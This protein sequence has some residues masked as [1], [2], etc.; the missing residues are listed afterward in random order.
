MLIKG[1]QTEA[2]ILMSFEKAR[3]DP[4]CSEMELRD[5]EFDEILAT[6]FIDILNTK[7][8]SKVRISDCHGGLIV[9]DIIT[10]CFG[11]SQKISSIELLQSPPVNTQTFF[12]ITYG[13]KYARSLRHVKLGV[14]TIDFEA[15]NMIARSI[16]RN[17][18][19]LTLN[20]GGSTISPAAVSPLSFGLRINRTLEKIVLDS[21]PLED[22]QIATLLSALQDHPNLK[23]LSLMQTS[24]HTEGMGAIATLLHY[25][26]LETLDLSYLVRQKRE[27]KPPEQ[28]TPTKEEETEESKEEETG[29]EEG[30]DE[31][32]D[33]G[34]E[35]GEDDEDSEK[36]S[37]GEGEESNDSQDKKKDEN[38]EAEEDDGRKV[39]NT[40]LKNFQLAGNGLSDSFLTSLLGIFGAGSG[41]EELNLFGNRIT[42]NGL[43]LLLQKLPSLKKLRA[44][45]LGHNLLSAWG[46]QQMVEAMKTNYSLEEVS[47][48]C[49]NTDFDDMQSEIDH[50]TRLN[51]GGRRIYGETKEPIPLALWPFILQRA[52]KTF[53]S[54]EDSNEAGCNAD[55]IF[56]LIRGPVLFENPNFQG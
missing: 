12:A 18:S 14:R 52:N 41:L 34:E 50:Y 4:D 5:V 21:C 16:A 26:D 30:K 15:G 48:R 20:L 32:S 17:T 27:D 49:F 53:Q 13:I 9:N 51:R 3:Q 29:D 47:L 36:D 2:E 44:L 10:A 8:W 7:P 31:K 35:K 40:K 55:V 54:S 38:E 45:W 25:N 19:L 24:C 1:S 42:D 37:A 43:R 46:A 56:S 6:A 33:T 11:D 28:E 23:V 39:R 22:Q